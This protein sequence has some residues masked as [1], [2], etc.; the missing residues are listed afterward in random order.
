[1]S[2]N[3]LVILCTLLAFGLGAALTWGYTSHRSADVDTQS[4][5]RLPMVSPP[6]SLFGTA[7]GSRFRD[8]V[9]FGDVDHLLSMPTRLK[10][11]ERDTGDHVELVLDVA[12]KSL[13][14]VQVESAQGYLS[15]DAELE[16]QSEHTRATYSISQRFPIPAGVNQDSLKVVH[17]QDEVI[18]R[19]DKVG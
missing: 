18:I 12:G 16:E 14:D 8:L 11:E 5:S 15:V 10:L 3:H 1:M 2:K 4:V 17:E 6:V 9:E 19:F 13:A 7:P